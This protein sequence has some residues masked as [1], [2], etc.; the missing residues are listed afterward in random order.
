MPTVWWHPQVN[1]SHSISFIISEGVTMAP[2]FVISSTTTPWRMTGSNRD[3]KHREMKITFCGE[4]V[5]KRLCRNTNDPSSTHAVSNSS[6]F[7]PF[8]SQTKLTMFPVSPD[9]CFHWASSRRMGV[10]AIFSSVSRFT[11]R[12]YINT[13]RNKMD[14]SHTSK[15]G[16]V[17]S[18]STFWSIFY[19]STNVHV[20]IPFVG[21]NLHVHVAGETNNWSASFKKESKRLSF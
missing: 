18:T 7:L 10:L 19:I 17:Q 12:I 11:F 6:S 15:C 4:Y 1:C 14:Q 2:S 9:K 16:L 5:F 3:L 20:G 8:I 13:N 21:L